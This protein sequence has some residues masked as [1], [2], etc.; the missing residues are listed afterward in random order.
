MADAVQEPEGG[1][2]NTL[3]SAFAQVRQQMAASE[4]ARVEGPEGD[5]GE[6]MTDA[7]PEAPP[8]VAE[9][10]PAV[11]AAPAAKAATGPGQ[12]DAGESSS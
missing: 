8:Q 5:G 4:R 9:A 3:A 2:D 7:S 12:S 6:A 11:E 1:I 10:A